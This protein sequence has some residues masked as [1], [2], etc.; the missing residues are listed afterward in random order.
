[1]NN[2]PQLSHLLRQW[3]APEPP[4][5]FDANVWRRIRLAE[6]AP[7]SPLAGWLR[8]H[9]WHP[10]LSLG[11]AAALGVAI[12]VFGGVFS[13]PVVEPPAQ[14]THF[15]SPGTLTGTYAQLVGETR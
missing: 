6:S 2:D 9:L 7:T 11:A 12:G 3:R 8:R 15:L 4:G 5:N 13:T 10:A 1:M 14:A